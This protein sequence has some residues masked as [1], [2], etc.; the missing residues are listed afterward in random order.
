MRLPVENGVPLG[1]FESKERVL[2]TLCEMH[3]NAVGVI[4]EALDR[5]RLAQSSIRINVKPRGT[6][7]S[8]F[9]VALH[10]KTL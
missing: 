1:K 7:V 5:A 10:F 8:T 4:L 2:R 6:P 9:G 3:E